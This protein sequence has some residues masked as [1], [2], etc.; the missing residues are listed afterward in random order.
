MKLIGFSI[1][2]LENRRD[3]DIFILKN[4]YDLKKPLEPFGTDPM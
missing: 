1:F 4:I 3:G 2:A